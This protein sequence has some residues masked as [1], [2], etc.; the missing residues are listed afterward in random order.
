MFNLFNSK[1]LDGLI[2]RFFYGCRIPFNVA[3]SSFFFDMVRGINEGPKGYRPPSSEKLRTS[4]FDKEKAKIKDQW[5]I[6]EISIVSDGWSN[7]KNQPLIN[8]MAISGGRAMFLNGIDCS[9]NE[10]SCLYIVDLLLKSI[11]L[12]GIYNVIQV[13]TDNASA[14]K[15]TEKI[16]TKTYPHI[17]GLIV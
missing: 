13:L 1:N 8:V 11:E 3:R 16:I 4:L 12:V 9:G 15:H 14:C 17:F 5:P 10:K 6:F 2:G 7:I